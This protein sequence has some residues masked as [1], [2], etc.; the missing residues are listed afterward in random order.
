MEIVKLR[1][2][3][4]TLYHCSQI[5]PSDQEN[6]NMEIHLVSLAAWSSYT[7]D[8]VGLYPLSSEEVFNCSVL[9]NLNC[10][11]INSRA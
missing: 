6:P 7:E 8:Q 11:R 5:E 4:Q 3:I 9:D 10:K 1:K 2:P